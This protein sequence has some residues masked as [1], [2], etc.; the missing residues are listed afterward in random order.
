MDLSLE[1]SKY[2]DNLFQKNLLK[3]LSKSASNNPLTRQ[4]FQTWLELP[5]EQFNN[6]PLKIDKDGQ[7]FFYLANVNKIRNLNLSFVELTDM[8]NTDLDEEDTVLRENI[9]FLYVLRMIL[10][11][12]DK[13]NSTHSAELSLP[14]LF[15][16]TE[17]VPLMVIPNP[18]E[19]K[20]IV[21]KSYKV[22]ENKKT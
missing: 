2:F 21:L 3:H 5:V 16:T 6:F 10:E 20:L 7:L 12:F 14:K 22:P 8:L 9:F 1:N 11:E 4:F 13:K 17:N 15:E 19:K 18:F